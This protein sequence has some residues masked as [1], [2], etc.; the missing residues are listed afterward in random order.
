[1]VAVQ[2]MR[3]DVSTVSSGDGKAGGFL[4]SHGNT[5]KAMLMKVASSSSSS[6]NSSSNRVDAFE[7][8]SKAGR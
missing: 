8:K 7:S 2:S 6:N 1:M 4:E 3:L 5:E